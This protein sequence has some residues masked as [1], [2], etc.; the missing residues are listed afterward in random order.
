MVLLIDGVRTIMQDAGV[1]DDTVEQILTMLRTSEEKVRKGVKIERTPAASYGNAAT[2]V[3]LSTHAGKA[4]DHVV[5]AM[6]Q[7][8]EGLGRYYE[9]VRVFRDDA[10]ETDGVIS[11]DFSR[12]T[13]TVVDFTPALACTVPTDFSTNTSCEVPAEDDQ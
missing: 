3:E 6:R 1:E 11:T 2:A 12:R 13:T 10:H 9:N 8:V 5:D 4:H 7:M